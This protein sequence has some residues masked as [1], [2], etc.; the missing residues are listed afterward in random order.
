MLTSQELEKSFDPEEAKEI[1]ASFS[2]RFSELND[3]LKHEHKFNEIQLF[4][5]INPVFVIA[6]EEALPGKHGC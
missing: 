1:L 4:Y 3:K 5:G 6:L 2:E